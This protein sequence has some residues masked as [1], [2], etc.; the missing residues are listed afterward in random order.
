MTTPKKPM[1]MGFGPG[2]SKAMGEI[3]ESFKL[4]D[5]DT[6]WMNDAKCHTNDGITWFPEIGE[7]HLVG[8]AKKFCGDCF[9]KDRC[10][11]FALDNEIMYG[12]WGGKS[13]AERRRLLHS[14]KYKTRMG[15]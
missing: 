14:R 6:T 12:V 13:A 9:V 3:L 8:V 15:L 10:L 7:S 1:E 4:V 2:E 11:K 5:N